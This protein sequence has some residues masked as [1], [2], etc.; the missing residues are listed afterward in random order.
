MRRLIATVAVA[1]AL[2]ISAV[3][4]R[5]VLPDEVLDDPVLEERARALS[6]QL[7]CLV[8]QNQSIDDSN[9]AL[10]RELRILL[11]ERLVAGDTDQDILDFLVDR[12]GQF[13]LLKPQFNALT[14]LLWAAPILLLIG[15]GV[16]AVRTIRR[17]SAS[18]G[19]ADL[20]P[21]EERRLQQILTGD[22][23]GK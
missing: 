4:A 16:L 6:V 20:T 1:F 17:R 18:A 22:R 13:V 5:A 19:A 21:E 3:P 10:A 23:R 9:A 12:Y 8:C 15:G 2:A 11:R 7:R 14:A